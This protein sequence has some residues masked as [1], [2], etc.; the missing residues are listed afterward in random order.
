MSKFK[1]LVAK[2]EKKGYSQDSAKRIA[3]SAGFKK[4]G[5]AGMEAKAKA[6]EAKAK[7]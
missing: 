6:G 5:K 2:L 1:E 3:A 7:K 4:Y